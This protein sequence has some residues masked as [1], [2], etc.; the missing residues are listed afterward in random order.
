METIQAL[1]ANPIVKATIAGLVAAMAVDFHAFVSWQSWQ[2][3]K[4]YSWGTAT[5]RWFVGAVSGFVTGLGLGW[6]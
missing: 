2:D 6:V 4:A 3:A 1:L 5:F